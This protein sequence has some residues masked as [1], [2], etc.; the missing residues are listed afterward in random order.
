M[1]SENLYG[2]ISLIYSTVLNVCDNFLKD[3]G[4]NNSESLNSILHCV[5]PIKYL[6]LIE[7]IDSSLFK[8]WISLVSTN[9]VKGPKINTPS[10]RDKLLT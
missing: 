4:N 3:N 5:V 10:N 7:I 1:I 8:I 6:I 2:K 9:S